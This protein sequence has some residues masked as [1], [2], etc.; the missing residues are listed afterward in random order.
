M[1]LVIEQHEKQSTQAFSQIKE[2]YTHE[3]SELKEK[4][5]QYESHIVKLERKLADCFR[6]E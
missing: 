6:K 3:R 1:T 2:Q 4:L 5:I